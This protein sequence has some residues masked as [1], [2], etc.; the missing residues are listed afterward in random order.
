MKYPIYLYNT[1]SR[2]KEL[3]KNISEDNEVK[4]YSCGPTV[5][6][7]AHLG[8]L[9]A[10]IF[11][12]ILNNTLREAGYEVKHQINITDVG[13]NV[14]DNDEAEDKMDIARKRENKTL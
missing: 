4:I 2:E 12:D 14:G 6:H 10:Y 8:N 9:R 7:Y 11:A 1:M 3:F 5:Y 13:H